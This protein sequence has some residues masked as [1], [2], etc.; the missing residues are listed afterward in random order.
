M[1]TRHTTTSTRNKDVAVQETPFSPDLLS[2]VQI[3]YSC[4]DLG[5]KISQKWRRHSYDSGDDDANAARALHLEPFPCGSLLLPAGVVVWLSQGRAG[6]EQS[7]P[8]LPSSRVMVWA[9]S[10]GHILHLTVLV[11]VG[12]VIG[13]LQTSMLP[14]HCVV[15]GIVGSSDGCKTT[16]IFESVPFG[17]GPHPSF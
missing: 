3:P 1:A 6:S 14:Q 16:A 13:P 17:N 2:S 5:P 4:L 11:S 12:F 9:F 15:V 7:L 8:N 10:T